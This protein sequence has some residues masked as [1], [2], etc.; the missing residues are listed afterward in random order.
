MPG[1]PTSTALPLR[2]IASGAYHPRN[3][4]PSQVFDQRWNKPAGWV[5]RHSGVASRGHAGADE[6]ASWMGAQAARAALQRAALAVTDIDCIVSACGVMEQAIPCQAVLLQRELGLGDSGVP[7]FD[8]NATCLGFVVAL[9]LV[10]SLLALDR[11]RRVLIVCSDIPSSGLDPD[12]PLT[13][14]LFGDGAV[15]LLVERA[16]EG[17]SSALLTTRLRT[18]GD[19]ATLC[20]VPTCGTGM[21]LADDPAAYRAAHHFQMQGKALYREAA[22]RLPGFLQALLASAGVALRD[23]DVIVPHQAS[24]QA[25]DH[26]QRVLA[27]PAER[28]VRILHTQGNQLAASLPMALHE[29]VLDG[30]LQRGG[31]A[32]LIGT[33]AGLALGG[34]VLRY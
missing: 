11:Y 14:P 18:Y 8:V 28:M 6:R 19:G 10:G 33:G 17:Q 16:A 20:Q 7:S 12:D 3:R 21:R 9:E 25:L 24:G 31:Q 26:L 32:L 13:A 5:Q 15:A 22:R 4:V 29:A 2:I 27:L 30:R 23:C 34:A 1:V